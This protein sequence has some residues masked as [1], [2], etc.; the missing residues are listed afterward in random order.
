V[1]KARSAVPSARKVDLIAFWSGVLPKL[2]ERVP[3]FA[4]VEPA[5]YPFIKKMHAGIQYRLN[6][7]LDHSSV[8]LQIHQATREQTEATY[9][10]L[11]LHRAEVEKAAFED[12]GWDPR[13]AGDWDSLL[14]WMWATRDTGLLHRDRWRETQE[15]LVEAAASLIAATTPFLPSRLVCSTRGKH[16][17]PRG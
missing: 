11:L 15:T 3:L 17:G 16:S 4:S 12:V 2:R 8:W 14:V 7:K 1:A 6:I 9:R 13:D 10:R 5:P